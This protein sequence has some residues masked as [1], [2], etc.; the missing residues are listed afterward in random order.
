MDAWE[1]LVVEEF[2]GDRRGMHTGEQPASPFGAAV[3]AQHPG[4]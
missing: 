3:R 4:L 2:S 1:T